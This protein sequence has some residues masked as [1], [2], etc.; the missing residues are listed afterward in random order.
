LSRLFISHSSRDNVSA[1]AFKQWLGRHG[2][3]DED[4]F[5]DLDD[6]GAGERWKE[7]LRKASA[8]CEAVI[9]LASPEALDSPECLAE[10]R[11]AEDYGK[12]IIVALLRDLEIE[13]RRLN[14]YRERQIADLAG[15]PPGHV[16]SVDY[17]GE[18]REVRFNP[19][20]L[21]RIKDYL[22]KCGITPDRFAWPP[23]DRPN[24]EPFPGL[25]AFGEDDAGIFFGR[26]T[27]ILNGLDK[28]RVMRRNEKP[29]YL[30]IQAA[31]GAGK[32]SYLRAGLWPRLERDPDFAP[33]AIV[34][35]AKGILTGPQGL[36]RK[37]AERLS[38][39]GAPV[40][41]GD[42]NARLMAAD[43]PKAADEFVKLA[44]MAAAQALEQR[45]I[46]DPRARTPALIL[47]IDQAEELFAPENEE[48]SNRF[49]FLV[50]HLIRNAPPDVDPFGLVTIRAES[51][52]T[53]FQAIQ[54]L[55]PPD[56]PSLT[57]TLP[58]LLPLPRTAYREI[59][60]KPLE[61]LARRGQRLLI[62]PA[63]VDRLVDDATG[64]DA[65]PLLAFTLSHL[66][67]NFAAAGSITLSQY[68]EMGGVAGSIDLALNQALARPHDEPA[69][70][71]NKEEQLAVLRAAFIPWLARIDPE[72]STAMRRVAR[73]GEF[74]GYAL[75]MVKR[76][77]E[78]RLLVANQRSGVAAI[79]VE[80]AHESLLRQWPALTVW[81][82]S[83]AENLKLIEGVDRAAGEWARNS[84]LEAWLD[85]RAERLEAAELLA[86]QE[87][88][89][90]R[91][92]SNGLAYLVAC[93]ARE[94][95]E[96][97]DKEAALAREQARLAEIAAAQEKIAV[98]QTRT[99]RMQRT[100]RWGLG[101]FTALVAV[102]GAIAIWQYV[103]NRQQKAALD[104]EQVNLLA[105]VADAQLLNGHFD[106]AL[107]L[108][109]ED[110]R[111]PFAT[112]KPGTYSPA[113]SEL[114]A[115]FF[116]SNWRQTLSGHTGGVWSA[117]YNSDG[118]RI[119]TASYDKTARVWDAATGK[120]L[121]PLRGH[122]D[123]VMS[124]EFSPDGKRI[125][126]ASRD[127]TACIWDAVGGQQ[128]VVLKGHK[129]VVVSAAFSPDGTRIVT[130]SYDKTARIWDAASGTQLL[131]LE[132]H[133]GGVWK[134]A[135]SP[136]GTQ[137]VTASQDNSARIWNATTGAQVV[138]LSETAEH[139]GHEGGVW[140][141]QF[142]PDG[143]R[144]VTASED[145]KAIIW[146]AATGEPIGEPLKGHEDVV[147]TAAFNFDGSLIVTASQDGTARLWDAGTGEKFTALSGHEG[148]VL[149]AA[150]SPDGAHIVTASFDETA[151]I[152]D[153]A[154]GN[155]KL[156]LP[157]QRTLWNA[158]FSPDGSKII[159]SSED[160]T[161]KIWDVTT[162][163]PP[164]PQSLT[165]H[166][167]WVLWAAF[168]P[169]G[170]RVVTA[171]A[172]GTAK[173]WDVS[174]RKELQTLSGH[175]DQVVQASFSP[176][177]T[178]IVTASYDN[179]ARIWNAATGEQIGPPLKGHEGGLMTANFSP[180]G[181]QIV[182]S[183]FD[184]T[185]RIWDA[186]TGNEIK[187]FSGHQGGVWDAEF[188]P[189]GKRI[190]TA[191][192][193]RTVRIWEVATGREIVV[194]RGHE[195]WVWTA[196]FDADGS[197]ILSASEDHTARLW[198][199]TSGIE[200]AIFR[201]V[202]SSL[203][204]AAFNA[205]GTEIVTADE[206]GSAQVWDANV[207]ERPAQDLISE[208]CTARLGSLSTLTRDEMQLAS[209]PDTAERIDVCAGIA[210]AT[211]PPAAP[212][213]TGTVPQKAQ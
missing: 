175:Q 49:L 20:G 128:L 201:D 165:G 131:K 114:A 58:P 144:I 202:Q 196:V 181:T 117:A 159:T 141:A 204:S 63:L 124:A 67:Q 28:I 40:L 83:E 149:S 70:P 74:Q 15:P 75:A 14:S 51:A 5:L 182:T 119:V 213:T 66:Y 162:S 115:A 21:A 120:M 176:D 64:A 203:Y 3:S 45:R 121:I 166:Q 27:D 90:E 212:G 123:W 46:G 194:L 65:L 82:K 190:V 22:F 195:N 48:E 101:A 143:K 37:L 7:A 188:S 158:A 39:P 62:E 79:E 1:K 191:S 206:N 59:I 207:A 146:N 174:S 169:D 160:K 163:N 184:K 167:G 76:L 36:V 189:D 122:T 205:K 151:R 81:L 185:A 32:S 31:S 137:I 52:A 89:R 192:E 102:V 99:A 13:D 9:L 193:D 98:E 168:S 211:S 10:L 155:K 87:N 110:A 199:A 96:R 138:V 145:T 112:V 77:I 2:W 106:S 71:A 44:V 172:D 111:L 103:D 135:F 116:Q 38:R 108:A 113:F 17:G 16:E 142:S 25:S 197:R 95:T 29:R 118:S 78:A 179:T 43:P 19:A 171:S 72:T 107:R 23:H 54:Q 41:A 93:R 68:E 173:V 105:E 133:K 30:V 6:I 100:T 97:K 129:D 198:N 86:S 177:G 69:I 26:D 153:T 56:T 134:A 136:D 150:F 92:G 126:T 130:A 170:T 42:I 18:T 187:K 11:K 132:G 161:A 55:E 183:S 8:R 57:D 80:V 61:V 156:V 180:D 147:L 34:R 210:V 139:P 125:V 33:L 91:I 208:S 140:D 154:S 148:G 73:L 84:Q 209:L 60:L 24:A 12:E 4:V 186:A 200:T 157:G 88:F 85:H 94:E 178:R 53:L 47:G 109:I 164:L 152:W 104:Q 35:P 50:A 127:G